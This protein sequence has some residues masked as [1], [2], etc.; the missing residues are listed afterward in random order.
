MTE[1]TTAVK[2]SV[3]HAVEQYEELEEKLKQVS[4]TLTKLKEKFIEHIVVFFP[5]D[6]KRK[7]KTAT[8]GISFAQRFKSRLYI[9]FEPDLMHKEPRFMNSVIPRLK[10][11]ADNIEVEVSVSQKKFDEL[12]DIDVEHLLFLVPDDAE[13]RLKLLPRPLVLV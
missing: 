4:Y 7:L 1:E 9:Y 8:Y 13:L 12:M 10:R 5:L 6:S 3:Q 2:P 11:L